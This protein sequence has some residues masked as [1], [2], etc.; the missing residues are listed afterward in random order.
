M[1]K[2]LDVSLKLNVGS[3]ATGVKNSISK[4]RQLRK[5]AGSK[6]RFAPG[7][8][9]GID[10]ADRRMNKLNRSVLGIRKSLS[11]VRNLMVAIGAIKGFGKLADDG[12]RM[13]KMTQRTAMSVEE[14]SRYKHAAELSGGSV[15]GMEKSLLKMQTAV[16]EAGRGTKTYTDALGDIGLSYEDLAGLSPEKQFDKVM[17]S[18]AGVEDETTKSAV[19]VKL[20]GRNGKQLLPMLANGAAGL[21]AMKKEADDLG[22]TMRGDYASDAAVFNDQV[23]RLKGSVMGLVRSVVGFDTLSRGIEFLLVKV[24]ELRGSEGFAVFAAKAKAAGVTA[25]KWCVKIGKGVWNILTVVGPFV[26]KF[27]KLILGVVVAFKTGLALP[28]LKLAG[29]LAVKFGGLLLGPLGGVLLGVAAL[30]AGFKLGE[31]LEKSFDLSTYIAKGL[32]HLIGFGKKIAAFFKSIGPDFK[33]EFDKAVQDINA[34]TKF[35][36]DMLGDAEGNGKGVGENFMDGMKESFESG[37]DKIAGLMDKLMPDDMKDMLSLDDI[38]LPEVPDF[39]KKNK[40]GAVV[41][42]ETADKLEDVLDGAVSK[43]RDERDFSFGNSGERMFGAVFGGKVKGDM[44]SK[45]HERLL[46]LQ[47]AQEQKQATALNRLANNATVL[48]WS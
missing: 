39:V 8:S 25:I 18:L 11:M 22:I 9:R 42:D 35:K 38:K 10:R 29:G 44:Q 33:D 4:M 2:T 12:D 15:E 19:A 47:L 14:L 46:Q 5:S 1:A 16:Y 7:F 30:F 43:K 40:G 34:E 36:N 20:F 37:K 45:A 27:S 21:A 32:N 41:D 23:T 13:D 26:A 28:L 3:F 17:T 6:V 24:Q 48:A 31:A